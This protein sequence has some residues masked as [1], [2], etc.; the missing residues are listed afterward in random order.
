MV[1]PS[2]ERVALLVVAIGALLAAAVVDAGDETLH[3]LVPMLAPGVVAM[4]AFAYWYV[5]RAIALAAAVAEAALVAVVLV[6]LATSDDGDRG[7]VVLSM[8]FVGVPLFGIV[9]IADRLLALRIRRAPT[10]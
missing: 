7:L 3:N 2:I 10:S 4:T 9:W 6:V 8:Y 1:A 5:V